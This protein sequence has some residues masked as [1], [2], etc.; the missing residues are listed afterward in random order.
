M[1][2]V[3]RQ[4]L[5]VQRTQQSQEGIGIDLPLDEQ[6]PPPESV[7]AAGVQSPFGFLRIPLNVSER[8]AQSLAYH[9]LKR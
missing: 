7:I 6:A 1:S 9:L 8:A 2:D 5:H 4:P 3:D